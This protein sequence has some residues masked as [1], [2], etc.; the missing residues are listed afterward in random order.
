MQLKKQMFL[1]ETI[2]LRVRPS[3]KAWLFERASREEQS[4]STFIRGLIEAEAK[5]ELLQGKLDGREE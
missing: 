5:R 4:V 1:P 2:A 3:V